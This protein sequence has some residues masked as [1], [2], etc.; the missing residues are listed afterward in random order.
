VA[1][2]R[3]WLDDVRV[4]TLADGLSSG[5]D[6][7]LLLRLIAASLVIYGHAPEFTAVTGWP[8]LFI[9]LDWGTYSGDLAVEVF[10]VV[11]GFMIAGSYLRRQH[12]LDFLWARLIRI[13][14]AYAVCLLASAF[15]LGAIYTTLPLD[16]YYHHHDVVR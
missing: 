7:F 3:Q 15:V 13:Y 10:F 5:S 4:R 16:A 2:L 8:D 11:S 14:P 6:N 9:W 12:L 1:N